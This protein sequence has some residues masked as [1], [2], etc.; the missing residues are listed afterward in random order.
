MNRKIILTGWL[1]VFSCGF[2][3]LGRPQEIKDPACGPEDDPLWETEKHGEIMK[4]VDNI[5]I[6]RMTET[7]DL[8]DAQCAKLFPAMRRLETARKEIHARRAEILSG[9]RKV[10]EDPEPD[11]EHLKSLLKE[12]EAHREK[13]L[14][15]IKKLEKKKAGKEV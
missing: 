13:L 6:W 14:K 5:R 15:T 3:S 4:M 12:M 1:L 2:L 8:D 9:I 10:L 11:E 7:L